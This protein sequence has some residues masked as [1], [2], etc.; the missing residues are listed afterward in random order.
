MISLSLSL[1]LSQLEPFM[2]YK[3]SGFLSQ[4]EPSMCYKLSGFLNQFEPFM[5]YKAKY[6]LSLSLSLNPFPWIGIFCN[7]SQNER[8]AFRHISNKIMKKKLKEANG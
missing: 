1:S 7:F 6:T 3:Q 4:F 2:C 5:C 8:S